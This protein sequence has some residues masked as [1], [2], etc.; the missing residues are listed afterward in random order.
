MRGPDKKEQTR[1]RSTTK[2]DKQAASR[3]GR[4]KCKYSKERVQY[5]L[6]QPKKKKRKRS[7]AGARQEHG[8]ST[9]KHEKRAA[10]REED[11]SRSIV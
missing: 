11:K 7:T 5:T 8:R 4:E 6:R 1:K 10:S 3:E 2:H 9:T